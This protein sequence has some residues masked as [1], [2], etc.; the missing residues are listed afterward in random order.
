VLPIFHMK[1][2]CENCR[3][4]RDMDYPTSTLDDGAFTIGGRCSYCGGHV[5]QK[6]KILLTE[7]V[8]A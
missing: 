1:A 7:L 6:K 8:W 4:L 3:T 2:H 5:E